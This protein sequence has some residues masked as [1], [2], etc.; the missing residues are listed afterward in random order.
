MFKSLYEK[1]MSSAAYTAL[2]GDVTINIT[3]EFTQSTQ[4]TSNCEL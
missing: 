1:K 2:D 3:K 4:K